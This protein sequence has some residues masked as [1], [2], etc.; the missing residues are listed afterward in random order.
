M[1]REGRD[2]EV[3]TPKRR[4]H[5][6]PVRTPDHR[7]GGIARRGGDDVA[8]QF[9]AP[10]DR[11]VRRPDARRGAADISMAAMDI[12]RKTRPR[13]GTRSGA[14]LRSRTDECSPT[15]PSATWDVREAGRAFVPGAAAAKRRPFDEA[16]D[17]SWRGRTAKRSRNAARRTGRAAGQG[18]Q[19]GEIGSRTIAI[20]THASPQP[21]GRYLHYLCHHRIARRQQGSRV[22]Q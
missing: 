5:H 7:R 16:Q 3:T 12:S 20:V 4:R 19:T 8:G 2:F 6:P 1:I 14:R 13:C 18:R 10:I 15:W 21:G 11:P 9:P 17:R 22:L